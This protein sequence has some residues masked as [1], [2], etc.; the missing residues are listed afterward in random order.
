MQLDFIH[1]IHPD[2]QGCLQIQSFL[3]KCRGDFVTN[4][5][6]KCKVTSEENQGLQSS[7]AGKS[8]GDKEDCVLAVKAW[9]ARTD[10]IKA[11]DTWSS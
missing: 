1:W 9:T 7:A 3:F 8:K 2:V 11:I 4:S 6:H 5:K 10:D